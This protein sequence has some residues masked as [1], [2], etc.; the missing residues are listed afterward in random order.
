MLLA[1]LQKI[2]QLQCELLVVGLA[3]KADSCYITCYCGGDDLC[4]ADSN[5]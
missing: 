1:N 3:P 5:L 2:E 4:F